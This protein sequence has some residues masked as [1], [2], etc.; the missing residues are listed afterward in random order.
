[1]PKKV[2]IVITL[3]L[4][5]FL[6]IP[7]SAQTW[8]LGNTQ[9]WHDS[10]CYGDEIC[11]VGDFNGDHRDDAVAFVRSSKTGDGA[12]DVWVTLSAGLGFSGSGLWHDSFCYG[13]EVCDVGD[14]NGDGKDDLIAFVR[15]SKTGDG[16]GDVWVT[17]SNGNGFGE[18]RVW[19]DSFCYGAEICAVGDFNGDGKDDIAAFTGELANADN[20]YRVWVALSNG[21]GFGEGG[22]WHS[23][24][25]CPGEGY[26][27]TGD[28]NNDNRDDVLAIN[29]DPQLRG[30]VVALSTGTSFGDGT[31]WTDAPST[32]ALFFCFQEQQQIC[33]VAD[34]DADGR[35]DFVTFT[36]NSLG[37]VGEVLLHQNY[38]TGYKGDKTGFELRPIIGHGLFCVANEICDVG[39]FNGD[40]YA[41]V[42]AFVRS[43]QTDDAAGDVW[44]S[45]N[46]GP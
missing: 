33:K 8:Q 6:A 44:V 5:A 28:F 9:R 20:R 34:F 24:M 10:F 26:C 23:A 16:A 12:G 25:P 35:D 1:M 38:G 18:G 37:E 30:I 43:A 14:F 4:T 29:T 42:I 46:E 19:H 41:D 36:R 2:F 22:V 17:L 39:D 21:N 13:E 40:G 45:L 11:K 32:G 7:A 3:A 15:S 31:Y 27:M